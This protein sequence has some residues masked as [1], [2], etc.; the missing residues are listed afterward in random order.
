MSGVPPNIVAFLGLV[1]LYINAFAVEKHY[2]RFWTAFWN[3]YGVLITLIG[4]SYAAISLESAIVP[5]FGILIVLTILYLGLAKG[6]S[7]IVR[8]SG[9]SGTTVAVLTALYLYYFAGLGLL[10]TIFI[11]TILTLFFNITAG[12]NKPVRM[13]YYRHW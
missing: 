6:Q 4:F 7:N 8:I 1:P 2:V 3:L 9:S 10:N 11:G 13:R 5:V 12:S